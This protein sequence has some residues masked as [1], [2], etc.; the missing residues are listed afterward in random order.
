MDNI[1]NSAL[2]LV[3]Y[4]ANAAVVP[5]GSELQSVLLGIA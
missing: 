4:D 2:G 3:T 1:K 5:A